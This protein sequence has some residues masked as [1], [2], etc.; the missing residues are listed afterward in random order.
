MS[1]FNQE[2]NQTIKVLAIGAGGFAGLTIA[3]MVLAYI[4]TA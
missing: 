3:L 1:V 4:V 2:D